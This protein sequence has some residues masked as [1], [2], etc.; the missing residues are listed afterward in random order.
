MIVT[1]PRD[2]RP[3]LSPSRWSHKHPRTTITYTDSEAA[4][5]T[6]TVR[7]QL[8]GY[9]RAHGTCKALAARQKRPAHTRA[10]TAFR[11][12]GSFTH[13]DAAGTN[14]VSFR[15]RVGAHTL[16]P[17]SYVLELTPALGSARG[18]TETASFQVR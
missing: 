5:T 18:A 2:S 3:K 13:A 8:A 4:V 12:I 10:C 6:F 15:D 16:A 9:R 7:Q 1:P 14:R 11:S 17:G